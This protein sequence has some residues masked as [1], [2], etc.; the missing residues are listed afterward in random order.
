MSLV[1][2]AATAA[3]RQIRLAQ[4]AHRG[5]D[6]ALAR[7]LASRVLRDLHQPDLARDAHLRAQTLLL[8]AQL[9]TTDSRM[10][11]AHVFSAQAMRAFETLGDADSLAE[12]LGVHSYTASALG[13]HALARQSAQACADL[14]SVTRWPRT[15]ALGLNYL[16]VAASWQGDHLGSGHALDAAR[17]AIAHTRRSTQA[18]QPLVNQVFNQ[19]LALSA[20]QAHPTAAGASSF[21]R[22]LEMARRLALAGDAA[23]IGRV[24]PDI[25]LILLLFLCAQAATLRGRTH[26]AEIYAE[27]CR[28]RTERLAH[29]SWLRAL[30]HWCTHDAARARGD[31]RTAAVAAWSLLHAARLGEHRP[32]T[33]LGDQLLADCALRQSPAPVQAAPDG[34]GAG[35]PTARD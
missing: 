14:H 30:P 23:A 35:I 8:A 21:H 5:G 32:L 11:R 25:G 18:F 24:S 34:A 15:R 6:T 1:D 22:L 4:Y 27:A 28:R 29:T 10:S 17:D 3:S 13:D 12:A 7:R 20:P 2:T 31:H 33:A 9:D 19:Y 26:D 16:G